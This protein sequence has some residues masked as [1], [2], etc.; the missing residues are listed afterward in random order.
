MGIVKERMS[1]LF[2]GHMSQDLEFIKNTN[3]NSNLYKKGIRS[4]FVC[5]KC[6]RIVFRNSIYNKNRLSNGDASFDDMYSLLLSM[7][8]VLRSHYSSNMYKSYSDINGYREDNVFFI[9]L[10]SPD[11]WC[12]I[13]IYKKSNFYEFENSL[14][15]IDLVELYR[16]NTIYTNIDQVIN[17][18]RSMT[19]IKPKSTDS[20]IIT[21][22]N[23]RMNKSIQLEKLRRLRSITGLGNFFNKD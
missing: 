23:V 21:D 2:C 5:N 17:C 8:S 22:G 14:Q 12:A 1:N 7:A 6:G 19:K 15:E 13:K 9:V 3:P 11:G 20:H 10:N 18:I 16:T 4:I